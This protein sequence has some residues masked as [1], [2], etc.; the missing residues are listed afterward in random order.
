[1]MVRDS[2]GSYVSQ[3]AVVAAFIVLAILLRL[4]FWAYT[5]RIWEDALISLTPARNVWEGFGLTHHV[6]EPRVYSFT[7]ALGELILIAGEAIRQGLLT[8][9]LASL[10]SAGF[11]IY[12]AG[13]ISQRLS[14]P[15]AAQTMVFAY[16]AADHLQ[17]FFG[18]S[19][20]ETQVAVALVLANAHF[21]LAEQ[22]KRLGVGVGLAVLCRPEFGLWAVIVGI[23]LL[24]TRRE[25]FF[26]VVIPAAIVALPWLAFATIYYGSPIPFTITVKSEGAHLAPPAILAY[27]AQSWKHIAPFRE[28]WFVASTP[29]PDSVLQFVV[30]ALVALAIVGSVE[31]V[32]RDWRF[33]PVVL[34][35]WGFVAYR[36]LFTVNPYFMWY[37]PPFM[38]LL[39][40]FAAVGVAVIWRMN[41]ATGWA[42]AVGYSVLYSMHLPITLYLDRKVQN[43]VE[44]AVRAKT[45]EA[46]NSLMGPQD[47]AAL[48]PLGYIGWAARNKTIYDFPGLG[49]PKAFSAVQQQHSLIGIIHFLQPT[50]AVLRPQEIKA[51]QSS[52]E[53]AA[54]YHPVQT[55]TTSPLPNLTFLG[56]T[57]NNGD[58]NFTI[59]Q[60]D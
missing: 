58:S 1:M 56:T 18:M 9:R 48:E 36:L 13:R 45:G 22:W 28:F 37:L 12:F 27:L 26:K 10:L 20:M 2:A 8:M 5:D 53:D 50:F 19:G 16:L 15:L 43:D 52:P 7:S 54:H 60:H 4:A 51:L 38:S 39:F 44:L 29:L 55:I 14:L 34:F 6:G 49:S 24:A 59:L 11:A 33:L 31:S 30:E 41:R 17:I 57:Y 47:T 42:V 25:A 46:L 3:K 21:W 35:L 32:R 23:A 40:V